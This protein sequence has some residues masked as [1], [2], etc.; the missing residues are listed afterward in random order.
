MDVVIDQDIDVN[1]KKPLHLW[2]YQDK[3]KQ[4]KNIFLQDSPVLSSVLDIN[5]LFFSSIIE[6]RLKSLIGRHKKKR[7]CR[8][9]APPVQLPCKMFKKMTNY[10]VPLIMPINQN[11]PNVPPLRHLCNMP[12]A[13]QLPQGA[14]SMSPNHPYMPTNTS[15]LPHSHHIRQLPGVSGPPNMSVTQLP[16][17]HQMNPSQATAEVSLTSP[18]VP[19]P[20]PI[21]FSSLMQPSFPV[22]PAPALP[23]GIFPG[24]PMPTSKVPQ[25]YGIKT[26]Q[27]RT[28]QHPNSGKN[29][30]RA[31]SISSKSNKNKW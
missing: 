24:G 3:P 30:S 5:F 19:N 13:L 31:S 17:P 11:S 25:K 8:K 28:L 7:S 20:L 4:G 22:V 6:E 29:C 15:Y 12:N 21:P 16:L 18:A 10:V 14:P 26:A 23:P 1:M 27:G 2:Y 9:P